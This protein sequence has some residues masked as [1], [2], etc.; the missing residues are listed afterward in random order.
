[1]RN[2]LVTSVVVLLLSLAVSQ[3]HEEVQRDEKCGVGERWADPATFSRYLEC[4]ASG[5]VAPVQ[6]PKGLFFSV[7]KKSNEYR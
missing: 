5:E 7:G 2:K 6:C 1:M 3:D 4:A